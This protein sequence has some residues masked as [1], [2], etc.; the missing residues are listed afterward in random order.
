MSNE[1]I[2]QLLTGLWEKLKILFERFLDAPAILRAMSEGRAATGDVVALVATVV[3]IAAAITWIVNFFKAGFW[4]K[5]G[6]LLS[7]ALVIFAAALVLSFFSKVEGEPAQR[8]PEAPAASASIERPAA[9]ETPVMSAP[10]PAPTE[11]PIIYSDGRYSLAHG[12]SDP[13]TGL[14]GSMWRLCDDAVAWKLGD[15][16][17]VQLSG[18]N[19]LSGIGRFGVEE[20][21]RDG[22]V[23]YIRLSRSEGSGSLSA[24]RRTQ[25][26]IEIEIRPG[27]KIERQAWYADAPSYIST[28]E[29][30]GYSVFYNSGSEV[31]FLEKDADYVNENGDVVM[32]LCMGRKL[33]GDVVL[34]RARAFSSETSEG[35]TE[36]SDLNP[37]ADEELKSRL[38]DLERALF[39][40]RIRLMRGL[41]EQSLAAMLPGKLVDVPVG[42]DSGRGGFAIP[43]TWLKEMKRSADYG[44]VITLV[45][46]GPRG[47][48]MEYTLIS[49]AA[50]Y[51]NVRMD[52]YFSWRAAYEQGWLEPDEDMTAFL[53]CPAVKFEGCWIL[54]PGSFCSLSTG[55]VME[56]YY[57]LT[58]QVLTPAPTPEPS[59]EPTAASES[60]G[61]TEN[62]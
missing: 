28:G 58:A 41:S 24:N 62:G 7:A 42:S 1:W 29:G 48:E 59:P 57:Y 43:C 19:S 17:A 3:L 11:A 26:L 55:E 25:T 27:A 30:E 40:G 34:I 6:M 36:Y 33:D 49:G 31:Q 56:N 45:G 8:E 37:G 39:D 51:D 54:D 4:K 21:R 10:T 61:G 50:L 44:A 22:D 16:T 20:L 52:Y 12:E 18:L 23:I 47:G 32:G 60:E 38:L 53:G 5:L 2:L 14:T 46:P 9:S 13:I 35:H 15:G